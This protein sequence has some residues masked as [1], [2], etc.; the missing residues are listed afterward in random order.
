MMETMPRLPVL[1][2]GHGSPMNA[3]AD[4]PFTRALRAWGAALPKP[5]AIL[6]VSAHWYGDGVKVLAAPRPRTI[7]DFGGFPEELYEIE[8]PAPG[9]AA[10]SSETRE[11]LAPAGAKLADDWGLDHGAW[12]PLLHLFPKADVPVFQVSLDRRLPAREH[13][14][15]G[16]LLKPLRDRG[17]LI[18]A[19]GNVVHNLGHLTAREAPPFLWAETFDAEIKKA[20]LA[21]DRDTLVAGAAPSPSVPTPDHY[22]PLLYA[23]GAADPQ[24]PVKFPV[25]GFEHGAISLRAAQWG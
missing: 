25:E 21:G 3:V 17:V 5:E 10:L 20:L 4:N 15:L 19:S 9:H 2:V 7:H 11:L 12:S 24:D 22:L 1:F 18:L 8:Y 23:A 16:S 14:R 6:C 13:L